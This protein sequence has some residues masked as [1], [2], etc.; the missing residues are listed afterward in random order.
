VAPPEDQQHYPRIGIF[1]FAAFDNDV[2]LLPIA[3]SPVA[4]EA[5]KAKQTWAERR[6]N[7]ESIQTSRKWN[8]LR[9]SRYGQQHSKRAADGNHHET[10]A[11]HHVKLYNDTDGARGSARGEQC[12]SNSTRLAA[13]LLHD[14]R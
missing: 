10:I 5:Y 13:S 2:E 3:E 7:G 12:P 1:Y 14:S 6:R 8:N 4:Q 9:T 11:G